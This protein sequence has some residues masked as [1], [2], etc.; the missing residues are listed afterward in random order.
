MREIKFR[1]WD[2]KEKQ[3]TND[4]FRPFC[5]TD[6]TIEFQGSLHQK[7]NYIIQQYTGEKD[8]SGKEIYE[9]DIVEV[10][11]EEYI[12][13]NFLAEVIFCDA[14]FLFKVNSCDIRGCWGGED[15]RVVGNIFELSCKSDHKGT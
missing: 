4:W 7:E 6:K 1:I 11:S 13:D 3:F 2:K 10:T 12:N 9:G 15:V 5:N 8:K 14:Q